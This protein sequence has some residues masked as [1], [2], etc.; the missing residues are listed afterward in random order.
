MK[1]SV[2]AAA[3]RIVTAAETWKPLGKKATYETLVRKLESGF[4]PVMKEPNISK[5]F[6][7]RNKDTPLHVAATLPKFKDLALAHPDVAIAKD[8]YGDTPLHEMAFE[9]ADGYRGEGFIEKVKKHPQFKKVKNNSGE[10]PYDVWQTAISEETD[11]DEGYM[12]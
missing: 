2:I 3:R 4:M 8:K 11:D 12:A 6:G 9:Y 1:H 7:G 5:V 10:T